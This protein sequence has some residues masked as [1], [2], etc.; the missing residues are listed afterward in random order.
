MKTQAAVLWDY[1]QDWS[2]EELEL[3]DP[4]EGEVRVKLA[5][6]GLCHSDEHVR[7]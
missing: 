5:S 1:K 3:D 2:I 4:K 7:Q 6:S